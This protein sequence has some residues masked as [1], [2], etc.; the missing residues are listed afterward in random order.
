VVS[1]D[2]LAGKN[3]KMGTPVDAANLFAE[4]DRVITM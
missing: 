2:D 4:Y 1:A 3:A